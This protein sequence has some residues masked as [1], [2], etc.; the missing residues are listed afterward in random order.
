MKRNPHLI[1]P[2]LRPA[3][4]APL[5]AALLQLLSPYLI[6]SLPVSLIWPA[7]TLIDPNS[8]ML[9]LA[10]ARCS[11]R[12]R[13]F[14]P[15]TRV[16]EFIGVVDGRASVRGPT[17]RSKEESRSSFG[18]RRSPLP[19]RPEIPTGWPDA[20]WKEYSSSRFVSFLVPTLRDERV[21]FSHHA[22]SS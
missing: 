16:T 18:P 9:A 15:K 17:V 8:S 19:L 1:P 13:R 11:G 3:L 21:E 20:S 10:L 22:G 4:V 5:P 6:R 7:S 14:A 2:T 12:S